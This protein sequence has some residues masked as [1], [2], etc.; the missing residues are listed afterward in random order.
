MHPTRERIVVS[1]NG[2]CSSKRSGNF[3]RHT[4][5]FVNPDKPFPGGILFPRV[6][7]FEDCV[8]PEV[9]NR[10]ASRLFYIARVVRSRSVEIVPKRAHSR[11]IRPER[12]FLRWQ[13]TSGYKERFVNRWALRTILTKRGA[14]FAFNVR[15]YFNCIFREYRCNCYYF[16]FSLFLRTRIWKLNVPAWNFFC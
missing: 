8:I 15:M 12:I 14:I 3:R 2:G 16:F 6:Y 13:V 7:L 4:R 9:P 11:A 5:G 10:D 1:R